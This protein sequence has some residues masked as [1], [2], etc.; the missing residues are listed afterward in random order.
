M[1]ELQKALYRHFGFRSFKKGQEE[2]INSVLQ[3]QDTIAMLPTGGGKSLCYQLPGYMLEGLVLIISPLLSLME[4]QV[5]QLKAGGE[6]RVAAL[7]SMLSPNERHFLLS[8]I[9]RYKFLYLSPE[10]LS[11]PYVLNRLKSV[12]VSLFVIDEAH[13]ISEWGHDF[14][15]DYSKLGPF[16]K[17]LGQPPVLALTATATKETLLDVADVLGL[18]HAVRHLYSVNRPNILL[19]V[20]NCTDTAEKINRIAEL[21]EKLEGPGIVYCPTRKWAEELAA[22]LNEKTGKRTDYYHG[23]MDTGDRILIQQQFIH[24]QLDCICCTN[25]FGMGVDKS[26]IRFVI[27]FSLPQTAEAFMQ[28]I[29]RAGRDGKPSVSILLRAPGDIELQQQII[30]ME[31]LSDYDLEAILSTIKNAGTR[32]ERELRD[33]LINGGVQETQAR[34]AVHLYLQGKTSKELLQKELTRRLENKLHKMHRVSALLGRKECIREALLAYFDESYEPDG[35]TGQ[36]CTSC[37][38]DLSP[39]EQK[40]ERKNMERFDNWKLELDRIFGLRSAGELS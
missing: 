40:G 32:E 29:G 1:T 30:Q 36:C 6:K 5:Q 26:D 28:E 35:Q 8:N 22:E 15:P 23:G 2:I 37:G 24:N 21:A 4:D 20:E 7:N 25:A 34:T 9:S 13:C 12:P 39:Y 14:R 27:H 10:A 16:R 11:S 19:A 3:K 33:V 18:E 38:I 31:S 17:A